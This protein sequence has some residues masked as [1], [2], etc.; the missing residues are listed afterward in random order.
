[1][2]YMLLHISHCHVFEILIICSTVVCHNAAVMEII[3]KRNLM[4][5]FCQSFK[6]NITVKI[7]SIVLLD[8]VFMSFFYHKRRII[9]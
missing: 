2:L 4:T 3:S 6:R 5:F 1:M 9:F 8:I 7:F